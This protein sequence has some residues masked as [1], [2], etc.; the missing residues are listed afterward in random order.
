MLPSDQQCA[1]L[2]QL[3]AT[4]LKQNTSTRCPPSD[5]LELVVRGMTH[6][7][8]CGRSNVIYMLAKDRYVNMYVCT[9]ITLNCSLGDLSK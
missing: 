8:Q 2:S 1:V 9:V 3:F 5:F 6:L 7:Q 4:F